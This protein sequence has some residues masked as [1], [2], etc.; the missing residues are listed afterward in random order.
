MSV[1]T[2]LDDLRAR[3][4]GR[5]VTPA[6]PGYDALRVVV[7]GGT[8]PRPAVVVRPLD[9]ADVAAAVTFARD[10]GLPLAVR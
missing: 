2:A 7:L 8:D 10:A 1:S 4:R 6:D 3:V 9:D 5:V